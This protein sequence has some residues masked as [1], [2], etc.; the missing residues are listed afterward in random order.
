M[1]IWVVGAGGLLGSAVTRAVQPPDRVFPGPRVP[2][3]SAGQAWPVLERGL[4]AFHRWRTPGNPWGI[5]WAAGAGVIAS[6][7][8]SLAAESDLVVRFAGTLARDVGVGGGG[9]GGA[10]LFASSASVYGGSGASV[11]DER[12]AC[13][14]LGGYART[15]LADEQRLGDTLAGAVPL[16]VARLSTLYGPGQNPHKA[17]GLVSSMCLE[18]IRHGT[19]SVYVPIDTVRDYLFSDDAAVRCLAMLSRA[20]ADGAAASP[21]LRVVASHRATTVGEVARLVNAVSH[22]RTR[23]LQR[24]TELSPLHVGRLVLTSLDPSMHAFGVTP[25]P[26]GVHA[27]YQS[28]LREHLRGRSAASPR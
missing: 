21:L 24:R 6:S 22:R 2:W 8:T 11:C 16:A 10:L 12:T 18:A 19:L 20:A 26:V 13:A 25:L 28:V 14:P 23:V 15:K 9:V 27:V 5:V 3:S 7:P 4:Q 17:Q 1:D